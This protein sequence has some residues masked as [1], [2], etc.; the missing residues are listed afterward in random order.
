ME[1]DRKTTKLDPDDARRW[2]L[3]AILRTQYALINE[4]L[5]KW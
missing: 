3:E 5:I 2:F 1:A 4:G